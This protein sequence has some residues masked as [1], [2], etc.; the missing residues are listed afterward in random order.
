MSDTPKPKALSGLKQT[1]A[2]PKARKGILLTV[3]V[4]GVVVVATGLSLNSKSGG[5]KPSVQNNAKLAEPPQVQADVTA[6]VSSQY[7]KMAVAKDNERA[8]AAAKS[9]LDMALPK[10]IGLS[11]VR[12]EPAPMPAPVPAPVPSAPAPVVEQNQASAQLAAQSD[13]QAR[14]QMEQQ[15]RANPAYQVAGAFMTSA[16]QQMN[17]AQ[18]SSFGIIAAPSSTAGAKSG[19]DASPAVI[20]SGGGAVLPA[21]APA[22]IIIGAGEALYATIDTAINTDYSGPVVAT[23][24]QGKYSGARI[25]GT[26]SLEYDAVVLKFSVMSLPK[27]GP[28]IPVQAF[29]INLGDVTKFG[30]TGLQGSTDYHIGKRYVLPAILAFAQTYGYAASMS[31][32]SSTSTST[33]TTQ[34]T[35]PLSS[36]D[37]A[38]V[39][40]GGALAPVASDLAR[41]AARPITIQM[42]ANTEIGILFMQDVTDKNAQA[43]A[44]SAAQGIN[45]GAFAAENKAVTDGQGNYPAPGMA[46]ARAPAG[47]FAAPSAAPAGAFGTPASPVYTAP[48]RP[49]YGQ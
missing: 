33:S 28:A 17:S 12:P 40:L 22:V 3:A 46:P 30:T 19:P 34:T 49:A 8:A 11:G 29:A 39:A 48:Y 36:K 41:Q 13:M 20:G 37:R 47:A 6:D 44:L 32:S 14:A 25:I 31:G 43:A 5:N 9:D 4:M 7:K 10:V 1:W 27:G 21:P 2:N 26:K 18:R 45:A 16:A 23:V 24:R 42:N 15:V 35:N 38:L